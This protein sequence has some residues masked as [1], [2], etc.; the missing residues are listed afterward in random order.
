MSV[1]PKHDVTIVHRLHRLFSLKGDILY[2]RKK[3]IYMKYVVIMHFNLIL[4]VKILETKI[5]IF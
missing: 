5:N 1:Q 4:I 2:E 3:Q